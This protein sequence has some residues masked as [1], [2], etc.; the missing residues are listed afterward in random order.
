MDNII[1]ILL[2]AILLYGAWSA[3]TQLTNGSGLL[4]GRLPQ[5]LYI[6]INQKKP[7]PIATKVCICIA[8]CYVFAAIAIFT[9]ILTIMGYITRS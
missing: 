4:G 7:G 1:Q 8:F 9:I 5:K 3:W 6:W 2:I